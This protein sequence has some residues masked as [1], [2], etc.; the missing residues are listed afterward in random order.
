MRSRPDQAWAVADIGFWTAPHARGRGI[1][2]GAVRI[3]ARHAFDAFG[4]QRREWHANV[5]NLA[6]RRVPEK[7]GFTIEGTLRRGLDPRGTRVDGWIG[8]LLPGE[9]R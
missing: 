7:T 6:S 9:L 2:T 4:V 3:V 1:M 8:S 5:G